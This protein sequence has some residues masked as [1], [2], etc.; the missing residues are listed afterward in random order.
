MPSLR[1]HAAALSAALLVSFAASSGALAQKK[2]DPGVSD[3]EI[4]IG[5]IMP[6]SGPASAYGVIGRTEAAYFK[7]INDKGGINGRKINFISYDDAYSPPKTVEQARKLVE[8]DE[9]LLIFNSLGTPPNSAIHK[10]MNSKKVPQLFVATGATKWNDPKNFP[11]TMGWQPNYQSETQIYAKYILKE[12]PNAKIAVLYQNDDYGK[13]YLKGLEDGLGAKGASM[14]VI[15]EAYEISTPT[16]DSHIVKLKSIGADVFINITTPKFA[17]QA[18]KKMGEI[19][20]KPTHFLNNVSASVGSVIKPAGYENAQGVIS[21]A[22]LKDV[23]DEQWKDD[24]GMKEFLA[25]MDKEFPE[26]NKLDG[27]T[28]VGYGVAQTLVEVLKKCGDNLTRENVM[29]Q[30]ASLKD[31][32]TEVLLPGIKINTSATD[33]AP[34]S[35]LQLMRFKGEKWELFG[36]VISADVGG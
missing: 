25:F 5:N 21:A 7:M 10:Y 8:S 15:K 33:F 12:M 22:Y 4:K 24:A 2:Y 19:G 17:A 9:V 32:R 11:W 34:V 14:I 29:K 31:Y 36:D 30:A 26:G 23:S 6:Y 27:G 3:T 35:Q 28:V 13:D 20:W 18:I 1:S 16:I